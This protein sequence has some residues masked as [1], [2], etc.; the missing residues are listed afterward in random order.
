MKHIHFDIDENGRL[1]T[2]H[3]GRVKRHLIVP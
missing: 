3:I 2:V 1:F